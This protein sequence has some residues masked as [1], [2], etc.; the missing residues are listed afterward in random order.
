MYEL[1]IFTLGSLRRDTS[2][3]SPNR[4]KSCLIGRSFEMHEF[5]VESPDNF[6]VGWSRKEGVGTG[7]VSVLC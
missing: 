4:A 3:G 6:E 1:I 7:M 2:Y 5:L